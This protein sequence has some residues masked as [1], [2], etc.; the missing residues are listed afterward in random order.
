MK[1]HLNF[2]WEY[3]PE[4]KTEYL[5]SF[6]NTSTLVDIPHIT[7]KIP[8]NYFDESIFFHKV[9]YR[10]LFQYDQKD[11]TVIL[12]FDGFMVEADIYL[13]GINLGHY[14][15]GY[16]K[17]SIDIS[18][19]IKKENELIVVLDSSENKD[20]PP[21]G[22]AVDYLT[23]GGIYRE[24][25]L[26]IHE[27]VYINALRVSGDMNGNIQIYNEIVNPNKEDLRI[28]YELYF[29]DSKVSEFNTPIFKYLSPK[30]WSVDNPNLYTLKAIVE[31][32]DKVITE[33]VR[34]GF[35]SIYVEKSGLYLNDK[36]V[37]LMG[38][39]RHQS[40]PYIGYSATK[41][42]QYE[43][44]DILKYVMG[45]NVVRTSHYPQSKHF[46][47]RCDEIGLLIINEIPGWQHIGN[48]SKWKEEYYAFVESMV[49]EE[50]NHPSLIMHGVRIDE[51]KDDHE[52]YLKGNE[53]AHRLDKSRPTI[54]VRNFKN[55]ELLEDIYGYNDFICADMGVGLINPRKA[56]KNN[57]PYLVTEYLGHMEPTKSYD[58][59]AQR[60]HHAL[61]H[62]KVINDNFKHYKNSLGAIGWCAFDYYT[63]KDFGSG[64]HIC[65]HGVFDMFRN[66]KAAYSAY[67]SQTDNFP[68]LEFIS[69]I[70][71]GD[72][73]EANIGKLYIATNADY[74]DMYRNDIFVKRFYLSF[75][76]F[77]N[78]KHPPVVID[79][80]VGEAF[81]DTRFKKKDKKRIANILGYVSCYG[82]SHMKLS[83]LFVLGYLMIK[84]HLKYQDLVDLWNKEV[85]SWGGMV[86][87]FT[88]N[89]YKD[90]K[91]M[92]SKK[93]GPSLKFDLD[94]KP[95]KTILNHSDTYDMTSVHIS[96][97]D[98]YNNVCVYADR[99]V[100]IECKGDIE[101]LS[102]N[103]VSL[104][105][106]CTTAYVRSLKKG[107]GTLIIKVDNIAKEI[108]FIIK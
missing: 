39:N 40:Y 82:F 6:P 9:I 56:K 34:F 97:I 89:A 58:N 61:R 11:K 104:P 86:K 35:R 38:L 79:D 94:I 25:Y 14:V 73:K 24:V 99:V 102:P 96:M 3:V 64:D 87:V 26:D 19:H 62:F 91:L 90:N 53:I 69:S 27:K 100:E 36:K 59:S 84:Y 2:S 51:S 15:S 29:S 101:L 66:K 43:D 80:Y 68:V 67:A 76:E 12:N 42:L 18:E 46:L 30:L 22:Y 7:H 49:K 37:H 60:E 54:G 8:T 50:Y 108:K 57:K 105:G 28:R 88:F 45:V 10:K 4:F 65:Y 106:G 72:K 81:S 31:Y 103:K 55:S 95:Y 5:Y 17:V 92:M 13:N 44:A 21:F 75:K 107:E 83:H 85:A 70:T 32:K 41:G 16:R 71:P 23:F 63:H 47:D 1:Q 48:S 33:E 78:L 77:K 52:L 98:E 74:I 20:V 93:L